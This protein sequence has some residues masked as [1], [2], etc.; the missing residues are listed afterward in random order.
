MATQA[1][2]S[3]MSYV[4]PSSAC[5]TADLD[6]PMSL[7]PVS[8]GMICASL[9]VTTYSTTV[10]GRSNG[11]A[12]G[13]GP[14]AVVELVEMEESCAGDGSSCGCCELCC[15]SDRDDPRPLRSGVVPFGRE[16]C[17]SGCE[18]LGETGGRC[19]ARLCGRGPCTC[20]D[21]ESSDSGSE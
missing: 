1:A 2:A 21:A 16:R 15:E 13:T 17:G 20:C 12:S 3:R 8:D 9:V 19:W 5:A 18:E 14:L 4:L 10:G 7:T 6:W 11:C